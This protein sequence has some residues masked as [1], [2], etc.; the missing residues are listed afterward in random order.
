MVRKLFECQ[1]LTDPEP[2]A[3]MCR[4]PIA[5]QPH[6]FPLPDESS[7]LDPKKPE[8][9]QSSYPAAVRVM[10]IPVLRPPIFHLRRCSNLSALMRASYSLTGKSCWADN[11]T[12]WTKL[13]AISIVRL[14][15]DGTQD[16][17]FVSPFV[18]LIRSKVING[19]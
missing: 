9:F 11:L 15:A 7:K 18:Y 3:P 17:T 2:C 16:T 4:R 6:I 8:N 10:L 12:L 19:F 13:T 14:N 5:N 1:S